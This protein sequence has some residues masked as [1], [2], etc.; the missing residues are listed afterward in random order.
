[1]QLDTYSAELY[2]FIT[3]NGEEFSILKKAIQEHS[4]TKFEIEVGGWFYGE[5][6]KRKRNTF[7]EMKLRIREGQ[8]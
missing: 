4:N 8:Q 1:M 7:T 6:I 5:E 2:A 3:F